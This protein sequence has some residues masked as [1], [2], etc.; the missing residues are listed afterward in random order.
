MITLRTGRETLGISQSRLA[1]ISGVSRYRIST[2]EMGGGP[3]K[4][5]ECQRIKVALETEAARIRSVTSLDLHD[6]EF[7]EG[8]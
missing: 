8:K 3:L 4:P 5:D 2:F 1:R 7:S 6:F